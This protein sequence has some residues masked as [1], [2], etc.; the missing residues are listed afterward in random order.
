MSRRVAI[1][2]PSPIPYTVGGA[3]KLWWGLLDA[4]RRYTD[5]EIELIKLPS[6]ERDMRELLQSYAAFSRLDLSHFD[7][8][9]STKYPAWMVR[10]PNH[11]VL[12]QH[13]LRGLYDTYPSGMPAKPTWGQACPQE[14]EALRALLAQPPGA[15]LHAE[16]FATVEGLA[17]SMPDEQ[18]SQW[19]QF[20]GPLA[21]EVVHWLDNGAL[22]AGTIRKFMAISR[23]VADRE[24]YFPAGAPVQV[25]H[26]PSDLAPAENR[27]GGYFFTASRLDGPKRIEL[28][29]QAYMRSQAS[30]PLLIAG[31]GPRETSL[32]RLAAADGRIRLLGRITDAEL[33]RYYGGAICVPFVPDD[34]DLGLITIEAMQ[35]GKPVLTVHDAGGPVELVE[36]GRNGWVVEPTV[37]AL[38][39]AIDTISADPATAAAMASACKAR[40]EH[41]TW[42]HTLAAMLDT[43]YEL[44]ASGT[45]ELGKP[46]SILVPLTF[47]VWPPRSGGQIRI[48]HLYR[49]IAQYVPVTLLTLAG[50]GEAE[51]DIELAPGLREWRIPKSSSHQAAEQRLEADL[52]GVSVGDLFAIEHMHDTP[53]YIK[54]LRQC[55]DEAELV[56]ASHPYLYHAI[57]EVYRGPVFYEAHNVEADLKRDMLRDVPGSGPWL[58]K[59]HEVEAACC[60]S[61][62]GICACSEEDAQR[63]ASVYAVEPADISVVPNGVSLRDV[64]RVEPVLRRGIARRRSAQARP[65][66]LF[67]ASWHGP[68]IEAL[69]WLLGELAPQCPAIDFWVVGS[70]CLYWAE[71]GTAAA[72]RNVV[73]FGVLD[74]DDK[75][76]VLS[77]AQIAVNPVIT[78]SGSNLKVFE[79]VAAGLPVLTTPFGFRGHAAQSSV[80]VAERDEFCTAL[81]DL[82]DRALGED[83]APAAQVPDVGSWDVIA[84][85]YMAVLAA[86]NRGKTA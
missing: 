13:R 60:H 61:A 47:P 18:W 68:N 16:F 2:A 79:Y 81:R 86:C 56:I 8:V 52:G 21:R 34:E 12:L 54:A 42:K 51:L 76:A 85:T 69:E 83:P 70:V 31:T 62:I 22:A 4:F 24:G 59:V 66:A 3:E 30:Q 46:R 75:N 57:R 73:F 29:V 14:L 77:S 33:R 44:D 28:L 53:A 55:C 10:H 20:P 6:P 49:R 45:R 23:T 32:R 25:I 11:Y 41:I 9:I 27:S 19:F 74:G 58:Q 37:E 67:L 71:R 17:A 5:D 82:A 65:A 35:A 64:P 1:V 72:P 43:R 38:G 63:L 84:D 15:H 78:G 80:V 48:Y 39:H 26:H 7:L 40:V 36:H 50:S